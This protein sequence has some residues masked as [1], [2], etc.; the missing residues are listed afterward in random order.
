MKKI[1]LIGWIIC[2]TIIL[3]ACSIK[4]SFVIINSSDDF[5]EI[6]YEQK[7][8]SYWIDIPASQSSEEFYNDE[9]KWREISQERYKIEYEKG[10]V[11]IKLAPNEVLRVKNVEISTKKDVLD[12]ELNIRR[13]KIAGKNGSLLLE[14]DQVL[15]QFISKQPKNSWFG[16]HI[17]LDA[18]IYR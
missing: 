7:D 4:N 12:K 10:I 5:I 3:S 2:S 6:Y 9:R 18:I 16:S 8:L 17:Q 1:I 13:L 14:G 15:E 11:E